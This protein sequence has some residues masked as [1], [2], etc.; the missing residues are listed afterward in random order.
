M[1]TLIQTVFAQLARQH[2][3]KC[4][5]E[6]ANKQQQQQ[7]QSTASPTVSSVPMQVVVTPALTSTVHPVD[8]LPISVND[9]AQTVVID[10][11]A[12]TR[13][14]V[15]PSE[16][17]SF[18]LS[19]PA[20]SQIPPSQP[21]LH[22]TCVPS[23]FPRLTDT[24]SSSLPSSPVRDTLSSVYSATTSSRFASNN[25]PRKQSNLTQTTLSNMIT[26]SPQDRIHTVVLN[27]EPIPGSIQSKEVVK[28]EEP[29]QKRQKTR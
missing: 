28:K 17:V 5:Q 18:P 21:L 7:V 2:K 14:D 15:R 22:T 3:E 11:T 12:A 1:C 19:M 6:L 20:L 13:V 26:L 25:S 23:V 4:Q 8:S 29:L 10:V 16:D 9:T 27:E 24:S